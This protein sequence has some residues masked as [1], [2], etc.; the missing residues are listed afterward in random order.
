MLKHPPP[1]SWWGREFAN[2]ECNR[3]RMTDRYNDREMTILDAVED[4]GM[5]KK[6]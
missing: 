4:G 5:L 3:L 6:R 1:N 2:E